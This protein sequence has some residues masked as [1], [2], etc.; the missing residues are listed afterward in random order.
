MLVSGP[1]SI[2]K[3]VPLTNFEAIPKSIA[4]RAVKKEH[5][6]RLMQNEQISLSRKTNKPVS[7]AVV[8]G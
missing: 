7:R 5:G 3:Q 6:P 1:V 8:G 2:A 4:Q